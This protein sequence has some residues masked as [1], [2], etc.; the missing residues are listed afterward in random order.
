M[1]WSVRLADDA[2]PLQRQ[3]YRHGPA[4]LVQLFRQD[5]AESLILLDVAAHQRDVRIVLVKPA[6]LV[7][8]RH[9]FRRPKIDHVET[10]GCNHRRDT[11]SCGSF[12]PRRSGAHDP[13]T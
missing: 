8:R 2:Q 10:A 5:F 13:T 9:T 6:V 3:Q 7:A 4:T 12:K 1:K 11:A